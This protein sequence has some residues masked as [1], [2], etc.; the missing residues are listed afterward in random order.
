[1]WRVGLVLGLVLLLAV[2]GAAASS[3]VLAQE[4]SQ[5]PIRAV[6]ATS[7][8]EGSNVRQTS[9]PT[10][11]A[12]PPATATPYPTYTPLATQTP[13]PTHTPY[14]TY[15]PLATYTPYPTY[16]PLATSTPYP[17]YTPVATP[18]ELVSIRTVD[19]SGDVGRWT[20]LV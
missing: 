12:V 2:G 8:P 9:T 4:R 5:P 1:M 7:F 13:Y 20:S 6:E 18:T 16:T 3:R 11:T 19:A 17:T 14:P 10:P 15:T